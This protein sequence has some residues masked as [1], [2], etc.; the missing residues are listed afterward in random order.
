MTRG[1]YIKGKS[2][3]KLERNKEA[4]EAYV[5]LLK[6]WENADSTIPELIDTKIRL[7]NIRSL[8]STTQSSK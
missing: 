1:Y 2:L 6:I 5:H 7:E 8:V 4:I 3:E